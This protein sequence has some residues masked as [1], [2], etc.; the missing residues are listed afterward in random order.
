[1]IT[2]VAFEL[3]HGGLD[4]L[5]AHHH[6]DDSAWRWGLRVGGEALLLA[7][8]CVVP[9]PSLARGCVVTAAAI[10][11]IGLVVAFVQKRRFYLVDKPMRPAKAAAPKPAAAL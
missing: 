2:L 7:A 3:A 9:S 1:V 4:N 11:T 6:A 8:A 5:L 10:A